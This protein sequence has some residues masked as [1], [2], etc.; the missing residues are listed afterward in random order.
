[1]KKSKEIY[2]KVRSPFATCHMT[3]AGAH[4]TKKEYKRMKQGEIMDYGKG[5]N[6]E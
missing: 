5:G 3:G 4:R 6:G 2:K 1:M